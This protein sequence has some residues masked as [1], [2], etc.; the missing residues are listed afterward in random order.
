MISS[1]FEKGRWRRIFTKAFYNGMLTFNAPAKLNLTLEVLRKRP[2]GF[3]EIKSVFQAIDLSDTLH[4]KAGKEVTFRCDMP[5]WSAE[6]SLVTKAVSLLRNTTGC[7]RGAVVEIE[8][9][10]PLL[11]G[12]G[13]DS[14]DA[15]ALLRGLNELWNLRL[16]PEKLLKMAAQLGSDVAFFIQGGTALVEGRGEIITPLPSPPKMWVVL[17]VPDIP[18][19]PGKTGRMYA[20]LKPEHF[21]GGKITEKLVYTLH[22]DRRFNTSLLFNTFENTAFDR[23]SHLSVYKQRLIELGASQVHLAGSGPTLFAVFQDKSEAEDL[24]ARCKQQGM[25]AYLAAT[26]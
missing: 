13:G 1:P 9:R 19:E 5:G 10:L 18:V 14:S 24:C 8:K 3:H 25:N 26:L 16:S 4:I 2:D 6:K 7:S 15:A 20:S 23:Y 11:S 22:K 21:T 17:I 12:L